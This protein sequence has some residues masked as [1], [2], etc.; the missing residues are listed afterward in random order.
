MPTIECSITEMYS[1][2]NGRFIVGTKET[3]EFTRN[4]LCKGSKIHK[5]L[6]VKTPIGT[7]VTSPLVLLE[8]VL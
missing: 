2:D 5:V 6:A 7:V 4:F 8:E 3:A 1:I